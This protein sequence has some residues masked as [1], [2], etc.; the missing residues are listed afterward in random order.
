MELQVVGEVGLVG[1]KDG[2]VGMV[3][4]MV[5]WRYEWWRRGRYSI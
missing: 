5:D 1:M 4:G 3:M 2:D